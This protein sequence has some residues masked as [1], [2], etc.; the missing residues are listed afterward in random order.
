[1]DNLY[2]HAGPFFAQCPYHTQYGARSTQHSSSGPGITP[3]EAVDSHGGDVGVGRPGGIESGD[4]GHNPP[5]HNNQNATSSQTICTAEARRCN[6]AQRRDECSL[7]DC[8][9]INPAK[10]CRLARVKTQGGRCA[11][12]SL[13][14]SSLPASPSLS[15]TTS[16]LL[17][18]LGAAVI[19]LARAINSQ[20]FDARSQSALQYPPRPNSWLQPLKNKLTL[21]VDP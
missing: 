12:W 10:A 18:S 8:S 9:L 19:F 14:S 15:H 4:E 2:G 11:L 17:I 6:S 13:A 3:S 16:I 7:S 5:T 20:S 1:M 21:H